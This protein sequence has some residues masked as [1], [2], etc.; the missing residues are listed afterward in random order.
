MC[1]CRNASQTIEP[2]GSGVWTR[3]TV[4]KGTRFGPYNGRR[5]ETTNHP[6][7]SWQIIKNGKRA[8]YLDGY[9]TWYS[10]WMRFV[11]LGR[12]WPGTSDDTEGTVGCSSATKTQNRGKAELDKDRWII[13]DFCDREWLEEC[14]QHKP[15]SIRLGVRRPTQRYQGSSP[16][17]L[18]MLWLFANNE[19]IIKPGAKAPAVSVFPAVVIVTSFGIKVLFFKTLSEARRTFLVP[20]PGIA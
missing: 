6:E 13:C 5:V 12:R 1:P 11:K 9:L 20:K 4:P 15:E 14:P 19:C 8:Q 7:Y 17:S 2:L 10:N 3:C 16:V 18:S